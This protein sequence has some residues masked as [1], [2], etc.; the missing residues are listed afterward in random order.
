MSAKMKIAGLITGLM[1]LS[2]P[3]VYADQGPA[4]QDAAQADHHDWHHGHDHDGMMMLKK[5]LNLSDDQVKQLKDLHKS[6]REAMKA[7]FEQI[8]TNRASFEAEIAKAA[9]DMSKI[10]DLQTQF[11]TIQGQMVD[12]RLNSLLAVKKVLTPEQFAGYMALMK[13]K[14]MEMMHKRIHGKFEHKDGWNKDGHQEGKDQ[15]ND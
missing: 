15:D 14:K 13:E 8:K 9:P 6:D 5:V 1:V 10:T 12:N 11:K 3:L 7:T 4:D 2:M